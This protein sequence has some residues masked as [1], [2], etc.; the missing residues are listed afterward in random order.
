[1]DPFRVAKFIVRVL[2]SFALFAIGAAIFFIYDD[3]PNVRMI[4]ISF[5]SSVFGTWVKL[6]SS[7]LTKHPKN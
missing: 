4:G 5:L 7:K 1:M 6:G 3:D 2:L